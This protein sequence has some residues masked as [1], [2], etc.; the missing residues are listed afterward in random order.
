MKEKNFKRKQQLKKARELR[1]RKKSLHND[2]ADFMTKMHLMQIPSPVDALKR[3][4]HDGWKGYHQMRG[5]QL[6]GLFEDESK[7]LRNPKCTVMMYQKKHLWADEDDRMLLSR[8]ADNTK[9]RAELNL[10]A[11]LLMTRL[12]ELAFNLDVEE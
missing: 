2:I 1:V 12:M 8:E 3:F 9:M 7:R 5:R 4:L 6:I 10:K 11:D